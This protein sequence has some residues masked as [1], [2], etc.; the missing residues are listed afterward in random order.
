MTMALVASMPPATWEI[1]QFIMQSWID[2]AQSQ[3]GDTQELAFS[4]DLHNSS[5]GP[6]GPMAGEAHWAG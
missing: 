2:R 3:A 5:E 1:H 4:L 6:P